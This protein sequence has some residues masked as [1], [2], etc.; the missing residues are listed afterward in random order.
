[1]GQ[2]PVLRF[3]SR[4]WRD[5]PAPSARVRGAG[6]LPYNP[7]RPLTL[8]GDR[9]PRRRPQF[10]T[11]VLARMILPV[12][13]LGGLGVGVFFGVSALLDDDDAATLPAATDAAAIDPAAIDTAGAA[14]TVPDTTDPATTDVATPDA[15]ASDAGAGAATPIDADQPTTGGTAATEGEATVDATVDAPGAS[16][17]VTEAQLNGAPALLERGGATPIPSGVAGLTLADGTLYD[18]ADPAAA[19][20]S[21]WPAGTLLEVTRL[22]G[23]PLLTDEDAAELIGKTVQLLVVGNADFPTELQLS[24]AA[25]ELIARD[26][27]PI[28]ALRIVAIAAPE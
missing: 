22:P 21:V 17:V 28:I 8:P 27:E 5:L 9:N 1:M 19:L 18:P 4:G 26:F 25:Y 6:Q 24:P 14:T 16:S 3:A 2:R 11:D 13:A 15:G 7:N 20:S 23:G 12:L 10:R